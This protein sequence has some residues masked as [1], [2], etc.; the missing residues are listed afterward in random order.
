MALIVQKYGGTSVEN[1]EKIKKIALRIA[2]LKNEGHSLVVVV[3]AQAGTTSMLLQKAKSLKSDVNGYLLDMLLVTGEQASSVLLA[4]A[5]EELGIQTVVKTAW[6]TAIYTD[7]MHNNANIQ[8]IDTAGYF[9]A[10]KE[11]KVVV[12][13]GFQ[14]ISPTGCLT[15]LGRGGSDLT[16]IALAYF[17]KADRCQI[18]KMVGSVLR[19][20]PNLVPNEDHIENLSYE[21]A[22]VFARLGANIIQP[23]AAKFAKTYGVPFEISHSSLEATRRTCID[24][25]NPL[26]P[27]IWGLAVQQDLPM[28]EIQPE[29]LG[30]NR[31][32]GTFQPVG[33][34]IGQKCDKISAIFS[35]EILPSPLPFARCFKEENT[36]FLSFIVEQEKTLST[37]ECLY[38]WMREI[39][40][41]AMAYSG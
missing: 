29:V 4:L 12:V 39:N 41:P 7:E 32:S 1:S 40:G 23:K 30:L 33:H 15:T 35:N 13:S 27:P 10:L 20:D 5:L 21:Q 36:S 38:R 24:S 2:R 9:S 19:V 8:Y 3:S 11:N 31:M 28:A 18:L 22:Y 14:G 25:R 17:L 26:H 16:A 37:I 6:Q 34:E